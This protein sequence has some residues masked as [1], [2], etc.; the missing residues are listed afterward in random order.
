M[1][2]GKRE[3]GAILNGRVCNSLKVFK[4]SQQ[5]IYQQKQQ[6]SIKSVD[7]PTRPVNCGPQVNQSAV[8]YSC[9]RVFDTPNMLD[10]P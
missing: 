5:M 10:V 4:K 2:V 1:F 9:G 6:Q 7:V 8:T 3:I